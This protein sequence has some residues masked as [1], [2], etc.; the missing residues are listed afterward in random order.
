MLPACSRSSFALAIAVERQAPADPSSHTH[1]RLAHCRRHRHRADRRLACRPSSSIASTTLPSE[2]HPSASSRPMPVYLAAQESPG[3]R[4][5]GHRRLRIVPLTPEFRRISLQRPP[6]RLNSVW[7]SMIFGLNGLVFVLIGLPAS[8]SPRGDSRPTAVGPPPRWR[9]FSAPFS[10]H[11][12]SPG[13]FPWRDR[14]LARAYPAAP[15]KKRCGR[16]R[17]GIFHIGLDRHARSCLPGGRLSPC[18]SHFPIGS[19]IVFL[20]FCVIVVTLRAAGDHAAAADPRTWSVKHR[21]TKPRGTGGTPH[22]ARSRRR[23]ARTI[24]GAGQRRSTPLLRRARAP[25]WTT[26]SATWMPPRFHDRHLDLALQARCGWSGPRQ[27]V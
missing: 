16:R 21:R 19:H 7:E 11:C 2:N 22:R 3:V 10:S 13:F 15:I 17:V 23:L 24:E 8:G 20:A 4:R 26:G 5:A 9:S 1:L 14:C 25:V 27:S 12:A 18:P 6:A